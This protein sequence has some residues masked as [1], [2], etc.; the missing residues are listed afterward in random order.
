MQPWHVLH[1]WNQDDIV[2]S[3]SQKKDTVVRSSGR[4]HCHHIFPHLVHIPTTASLQMVR[5]LRNF[6]VFS[7]NLNIIFKKYFQMNG[8]AQLFPISYHNLS[9][10][11]LTSV[12]NAPFSV[13]TANDASTSAT[14]LTI[15][16]CSWK[17]YSIRIMKVSAMRRC[18][19]VLT[20]WHTHRERHITVRVNAMVCTCIYSNSWRGKQTWYD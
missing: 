8:Y 10:T 11:Y 7:L 5:I 18:T 14:R 2:K 20:G 19:V 1:I 3:N 6:G 15:S 9:F 16:F 17:S 4:S 12:S 13:L